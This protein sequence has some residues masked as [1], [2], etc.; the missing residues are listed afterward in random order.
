[1]GLEYVSLQPKIDSWLLFQAKMAQKEKAYLTER[2]EVTSKTFEGLVSSLTNMVCD[3]SPF[4]LFCF[5]NV[6]IVCCSNDREMR[7]RT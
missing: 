5:L 7:K 2:S 1:M 3:Q 6:N 4:V